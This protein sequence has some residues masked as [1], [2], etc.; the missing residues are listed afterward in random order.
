MGIKEKMARVRSALLVGFLS[1]LSF[2]PLVPRVTSIYEAAQDTSTAGGVPDQSL[3]LTIIFPETAKW[4]SVADM[5][6]VESSDLEELGTKLK[7]AYNKSKIG[8]RFEDSGCPLINR[9]LDKAFS[10][11]LRHLHRFDINADGKDDIIY[12]G[13]SFCSDG[14]ITIIWF[15]ND[16]DFVIPMDYLWQRKALKIL[17]GKNVEVGIIEAGCCGSLF[18]EYYVGTLDS[19]KKNADPRIPGRLRPQTI[20][21]RTTLPKVLAGPTA[22]R[23]IGPELVLRFSPEIQNGYDE[24]ASGFIDNAVFG[25]ILSRYMP[26]CK[27]TIIGENKEEGIDLW[28]FVLLDDCGPLRI[29]SPF[30]V[31]AGWVKASEI[32]LVK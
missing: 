16:P 15:G 4:I 17:P 5:P 9:L 27:G 20:L 10:F 7:D 29:H 32:E 3:V 26:G 23:A 28:Y 24:S 11:Y 6:T 1:Y 14:D 25:N 31:T 2:Q 19:P 22:F 12:A 8:Q 18:D 13:Q 21:K 30:E